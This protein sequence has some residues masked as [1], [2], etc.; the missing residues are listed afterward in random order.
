MKTHRNNFK[1]QGEA[2]KLF[3]SLFTVGNSGEDTLRCWNR[4]P[5]YVAGFEFKSKDI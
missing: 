3:I 1:Q 5:E 2:K 4:R